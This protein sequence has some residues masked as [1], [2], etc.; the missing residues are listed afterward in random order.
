M[1]ARSLSQSWSRVAT[2]PETVTVTI[3]VAAPVV[4]EVSVAFPPVAVDLELIKLVAGVDSENHALIALTAV[5]PR[6]VRVGDEEI[7]LREVI[8]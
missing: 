6:R 4:E 5:H 3:A 7:R 8:G 2:E 1:L